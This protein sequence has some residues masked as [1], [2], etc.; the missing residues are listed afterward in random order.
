MINDPKDNC[1]DGDNP[2]IGCWRELR[3][4]IHVLHDGVPQDLEEEEITVK[5]FWRKK[6]NLVEKLLTKQQAKDLA[7]LQEKVRFYWKT[8]SPSSIDFMFVFH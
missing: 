4:A 1:N 8:L 2:A 3:Y 6:L 7:L 5:G